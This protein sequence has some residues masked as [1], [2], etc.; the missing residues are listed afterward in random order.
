MYMF[1]PLRPRS[2]WPGNDKESL[3]IVNFLYSFTLSDGLLDS[4]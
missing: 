3:V 4:G 1:V 2:S